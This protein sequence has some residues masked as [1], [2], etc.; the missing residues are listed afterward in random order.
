MIDLVTYRIRIG[1]F[2]CKR[3]TVKSGSMTNTDHSLSSSSQMHTLIDDHPRFFPWLLYLIFITYFIAISMSLTLSFQ[4]KLSNQFHSLPSSMISTT[5]ISPL[6]LFYLKLFSAIICPFVAKNIAM[7]YRLSKIRFSS[8][9]NRFCC[10]FL[11]WIY[12]LNAFLVIV[13][14]PSLLNPGPQYLTVAYQNVQGLIPFSHLNSNQPLLDR[15]KISELQ[16]F[17][18]QSKPD[19]IVLNE[20]WLKKS[21]TN[22]EILPDSQYEVF[23]ND[24]TRK[25]HPQDVNNPKKFREH[26]GGVLI[27]VKSDLDVI[28][29]RLTVSLG[30]EMLAIK[31]TFPNKE[32]IVICTCYRVGTLGQLHHDTLVSY[33]RTITSKRNPPKVYLVGDLN[34]PQANWS[35]SLSN[36]PLEQT[37]LNSFSS[38]CLS[39]L[40]N[41]PTHK[42]GNTLDILLSNSETSVE[43]LQVLD[44]HS[45]CKSDHFPVS[46]SIKTT[47]SRKKTPKRSVYNFK[48]AN[49]AQLNHELRS[50][51]WTFLGSAHPDSA[52]KL[53][54]ECLLNLSD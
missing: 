34:L 23:R 48:K 38:L 18:I 37:F 30:L 7:A 6:V 39:Q 45:F 2:A 43:N 13:V 25:T 8:R 29:K 9:I 22:N 20:T 31:I 5:I 21:V 17:A 51:D 24:R 27:A 1:L 40:I 50:V 10:L 3:H 26:G 4:T 32:S 12:S 46:F 16:A 36:V 14:N 33:L 52:W 35:S 54:K 49:W 44:S 11:L 41:I 28:T 19:I 47:F 15:N 42:N 53:L